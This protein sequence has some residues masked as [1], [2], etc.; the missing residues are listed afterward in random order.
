MIK[1]VNLKFSYNS[2]C[3]NIKFDGI[4]TVGSK[5]TLNVLETYSEADIKKLLN[6]VFV[7][8]GIIK[9]EVKCNQP[10]RRPRLITLTTTL[11]I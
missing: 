1:N 6:E 11:I 3:G 8:S 4:R 2:K 9:A 10:S 7:I 5:I